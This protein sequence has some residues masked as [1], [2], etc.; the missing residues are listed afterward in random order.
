MIMDKTYNLPNTLR[1]AVIG[2]ISF[3]FGIMVLCHC[4]LSC[5]LHAPFCFIIYL[6]KTSVNV[7]LLVNI[8]IP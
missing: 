3:V 1:Y 5:K 6:F 2:N 4:S 7:I 8:N